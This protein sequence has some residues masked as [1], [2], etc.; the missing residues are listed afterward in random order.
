MAV[1]IIVSSSSTYAQFSGDLEE[2]GPI[3]ATFDGQI[4]ENVRITAIDEY[5]IDVRNLS[6]VIIRNVEIFHDGAHGIRCT[7]APGIII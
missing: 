6:N 3:V 4:I 2:S 5:G 7:S 1:A